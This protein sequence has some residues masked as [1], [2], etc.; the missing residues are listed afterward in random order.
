MNKP[1][2]DPIDEYNNSLKLAVSSH[3]GKCD[4]NRRLSGFSKAI[5]PNESHFHPSLNEHVQGVPPLN[6]D[7]H[8]LM[9][10]S[11]QQHVI[12]NI[13][14]APVEPQLHQV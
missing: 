3:S 14:Q 12:K 11:T 7:T 2:Q 8:F 9:K 10:A 1:S 6:P 13:L 4:K 5:S